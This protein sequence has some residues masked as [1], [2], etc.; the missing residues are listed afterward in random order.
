MW[1]T[2][3]DVS[4]GEILYEHSMRMCEWSGVSILSAEQGSERG[5]EVERSPDEVTRSLAVESSS[6]EVMDLVML[7]ERSTSRTPFLSQQLLAQRLSCRTVWWW[8]PGVPVLGTIE[9]C[10]AVDN[11]LMVRCFLSAASKGNWLSRGDYEPPVPS[12]SSL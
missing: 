8:R 3:D 9:V 7:K 6:G 5:R 1:P 2:T 4:F 12:E 10:G 11:V